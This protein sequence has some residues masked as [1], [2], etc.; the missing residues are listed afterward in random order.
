MQTILKV[1]GILGGMA[2]WISFLWLF[3]RSRPV[4]KIKIKGVKL[5]HEK[6]KRLIFDAVVYNAGQKTAYNSEGGHIIFDNRFNDEEA[7]GVV[8][9][10]EI[11]DTDYDFAK[12][13]NKIIDIRAKERRRCWVDH[14]ISIKEHIEGDIKIT[15]FP[16][17]KKKGAYFY[18][19]FLCFYGENFCFDYL[20]GRVKE[21]IKIEDN[22]SEVLD[23]IEWIWPKRKLL[24][25]IRRL[26][27]RAKIKRLDFREYVRPT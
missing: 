6:K 17:G 5:E 26:T 21:E 11:N 4:L 20:K 18:F 7:Q 3:S 15:F 10:K 2:G 27:L 9:W 12:E 22:Y 14:D 23:K 13:E 1:L 25:S 16:Y 8:F 24:D 19:V